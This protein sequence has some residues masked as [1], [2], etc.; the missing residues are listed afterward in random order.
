MYSQTN[1]SSEVS[2]RDAIK[3]ENPVDRL[4]ISEMATISSAVNITLTM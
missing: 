4:A 2:G 1:A 3:A